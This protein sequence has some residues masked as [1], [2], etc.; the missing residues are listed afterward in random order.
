MP[1]FSALLKLGVILIKLEVHQLFGILM[2][3]H[4]NAQNHLQNSKK[5]RFISWNHAYIH[6]MSF[7]EED[8][9]VS[10]NLKSTFGRGKKLYSET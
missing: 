4:S 6:F 7:A 5:L 1:D 8:E 2:P 3:N 9:E 10:L